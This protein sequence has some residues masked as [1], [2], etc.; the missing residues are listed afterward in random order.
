LL[1]NSGAATARGAGDLQ[2]RDRN[3]GIETYMEVPADN[4]VGIVHCADTIVGKSSRPTVLSAA[5]KTV[6]GR[7]YCRLR[8]GR[9]LA[10]SST[11]R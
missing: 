10:A 7:Q 3:D 6:C 2:D 4:C 9:L 11:S 5:D 1:R 8:Y